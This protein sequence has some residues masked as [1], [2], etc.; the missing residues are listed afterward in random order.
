MN[1]N[2]NSRYTIQGNQLTI[3]DNLIKF[4]FPIKEFVE[5]SDMLIMRLEIPLNKVSNE[6]VF[7]VS[8]IEKKIKWRVAKLKYSTGTDCPFVA[9]KL[10]SHKLYLY[11]WCD[12]YLIVDPLTGEILERSLPMKS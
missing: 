12:I 6:N 10:H 3:G 11:N 4:D 5:I 8:L 9:L 1:L 7:G 2:K